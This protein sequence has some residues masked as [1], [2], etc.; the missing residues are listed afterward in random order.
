M[1]PAGLRAR[2]SGTIVA[3]VEGRTAAQ[4]RGP[5]REQEQHADDEQRHRDI[6]HRD[7]QPADER[8]EVVGLRRGAHEM[9]F[10]SI[11]TAV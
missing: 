11:W 10:M 5:G 9:A 3:E 7:Q 4:R 2:R 6:G 1:N 8:L